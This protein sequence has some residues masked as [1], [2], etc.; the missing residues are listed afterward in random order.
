MLKIKLHSHQAL[1]FCHHVNCVTR[2]FK[3]RILIDMSFKKF[4]H[5]NQYFPKQKIFQS[6]LKVTGKQY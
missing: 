5:E 6:H 3:N 2:D 1:K 4:L